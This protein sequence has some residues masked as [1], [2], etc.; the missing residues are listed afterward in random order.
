[1]AIAEH[2]IAH[3]RD[4]ARSL[5]EHAQA[6]WLWTRLRDGFPDAFSCE[7]MCNHVHLVAPPGGRARFVRVLAMF[8][9][10]CGIRFDVMVE[11]ANN[12]EITARMIR[13]GFHNPLQ[14]R[15]VA[16]PYAWRWSTLRDLVGAAYPIWTP[17]QRVAHALGLRPERLLR[18]V[19]HNADL[20]P[21]RPELTDAVAAS[22]EGLCTATSAALRIDAPCQHALG[23]RLV[24]QAAYAVGAPK[25]TELTAALGCS[26]RM[27]ERTR[28]RR[29]PA[30]HAVLLCLGDARLRH[31][32]APR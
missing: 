27:I 2:L 28:G 14:D 10:R 30:L 29:H 24:V 6:S 31:P 22:V 20:R 9:A 23:R 13:Y 4:G 25:W 11:I 15:L 5:L 3:T 19:T 18:L 21:R 12:V 16:D 26:Q 7:L 8:T 1:M 32:A 17:M